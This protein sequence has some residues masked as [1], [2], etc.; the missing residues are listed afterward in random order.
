MAWFASTQQQY[1]EKEKYLMDG[2]L[3]L[4][5]TFWER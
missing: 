2:A 5:K 4:A 1:N 3:K